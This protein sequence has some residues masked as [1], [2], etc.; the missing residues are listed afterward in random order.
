LTW[1]EGRLKA[2]LGRLLASAVSR[3]GADFGAIRLSGHG[4]SPLNLAAHAGFP[5]EWAQACGDGSLGDGPCGAALAQNSR[6]D[7]YDIATCQIFAKGRCREL[8]LAAGARSAFAQPIASAAGRTIGAL[9]VY[10]KDPH[11]LSDR[12][13]EILELLAGHAGDLIEAEEA[14]QALRQ[15]EEKLLWLASFPDRNPIVPI[16]EIDRAGKLFYMNPAATRLF[17]D[18]AEKRLFHPWLAGWEGVLRALEKSKSRALERAVD[19]GASSFLQSIYYLSD[20]D[21]IR[22]YGLDATKMKKLEGDLQRA[23]ES[24]DEFLSIVSHELKTPIASLCLQTQVLGRL[25]GKEPGLEPLAAR[26]AAVAAT[27]I[28]LARLI[29]ELL[30]FTKIRAG[31]LSLQ[32]GKVDLRAAAI[33]EL[34]R[35]ASAQAPG[36]NRGKLE[37]QIT[38]K[39]G[40]PVVGHWDPMR[41]DQVLSNL[42]SNAIKYGEGRPIEIDI[43]TDRLARSA[44]LAVRDHGIGIHPDLQE[45]I[46]RRFERG[47]SSEKFS[48]LGLGL[49]IVEKIVKAHDGLLRVE[50]EPGKGSVFICELPLRAGSTRPPASRAH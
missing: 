22:I 40:G 16:V 15:N 21:R 35:Q 8:A 34:S 49:Y 26:S 3:A 38:I 31:Q 25:A 7:A 5:R 30:D 6:A 2:R 23:I 9:S 33:D 41:I 39:A 29:D 17:P 32:K 44:R 28:K 48:G 37:E 19:C 4:G 43:S 11:R 18:L 1:D 12:E 50:S 10:Y 45:K 42:L 20:L 13:A 36:R 46:F 14:S 47:V 24:R 27:S